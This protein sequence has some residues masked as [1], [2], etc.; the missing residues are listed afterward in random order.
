MQLIYLIY[1][2]RVASHHYWTATGLQMGADGPEPKR[3]RRA[4]S[5]I[6]I[7]PV[8]NDFNTDKVISNASGGGR[9]ECSEISVY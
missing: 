3:Q 8:I 4:M 2:L 7:A 5:V 6:S 1:F 9:G